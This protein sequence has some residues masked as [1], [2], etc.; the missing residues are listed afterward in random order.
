MPNSSAAN[1]APLTTGTR[2]SATPALASAS[3]P[4]PGTDGGA[5]PGVVAR[6]EST[7]RMSVGKPTVLLP[8]PTPVPPSS[9]TAVSFPSPTAAPTPAPT[10][11]P[12]PASSPMRSSRLRSCHFQSHDA[13]SDSGT[14]GGAVPGVVARTESTRRMS[15]GKPTVLLPSPTPVPLS[16][17]TAVS[18]PSPTA[19]PT[20][21]PTA[22]PFPASSPVRSS[23]LRSCHFQ[24]HDA[25]SG[26]ALCHFQCQRPPAPTAMPLPAPTAVPLP[27]PMAMPLPAPTAVPLPTPGALPVPLVPLPMPTVV[28]LPTPAVVP[29][30][31][32]AAL[33]FPAI[34][35]GPNDPYWGV[36]VCLS[37]HP[38]RGRRLRATGT[39]QLE[40]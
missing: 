29:Q 24:S 39:P 36:G 16:S 5:V 1:R 21:A 13:C 7:R 11:V 8:S 30:A 15:V 35:R 34:G 40:L 31:E 17:P 26:S 20:P 4:S 27:M 18:F 10:A 25:C 28:P 19:A 6:A 12:F 9:P 2:L 22:V 23:R 33:P 14:D 37:R 32:P 38:A 3:S